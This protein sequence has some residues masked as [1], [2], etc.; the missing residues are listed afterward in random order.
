MVLPQAPNLNHTGRGSLVIKK[1]ESES[2]FLVSLGSSYER[3]DS[4]LGIGIGFSLDRVLTLFSCFLRER[5]GEGRASPIVSRLENS[6][7][8]STLK[9]LMSYNMNANAPAQTSSPICTPPTR[10]STPRCRRPRAP[11][12]H[13]PM[14]KSLSG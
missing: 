8:K 10:Y 11:L 2:D 7:F 3:N 14:S 5:N 9:M 1:P 13:L 12:S 6:Q 4:K